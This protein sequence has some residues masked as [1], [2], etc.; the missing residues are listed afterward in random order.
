VVKRISMDKEKK[1]INNPGNGVA[2]TVYKYDD[3]GK[4]TE[5]LQYDKENVLVVPKK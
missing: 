1:I 5:T 4:R 3:Q 2:I